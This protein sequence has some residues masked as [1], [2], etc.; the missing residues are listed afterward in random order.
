MTEVPL[1]R[2]LHKCVRVVLPLND[3]FPVVVV[4]KWL[5]FSP[6]VVAARMCFCGDVIPRVLCETLGQDTP[7]SG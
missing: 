1:W 2:W 3:C 7:A 6:V 4:G 5:F